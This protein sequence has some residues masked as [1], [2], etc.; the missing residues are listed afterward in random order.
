MNGARL[1]LAIAVAT[2]G[3]VGYDG[4][5]ESVMAESATHTT[6]HV[7]EDQNGPAAVAARDE[8]DKAAQFRRARQMALIDGVVRDYEP[9][10]RELG[11]R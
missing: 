7:T 8:R 4:K 11:Q 6:E 10:L 3:R 2:F 1:G 5:Q 9:V